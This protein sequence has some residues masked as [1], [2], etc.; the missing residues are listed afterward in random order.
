[1]SSP[2]KGS[3]LKLL[4]L[5]QDLIEQ[6]QDFREAYL[7]AN[8]NTIVAEALS[9]FINTQVDSNPEIRRRYKAARDR[10]R[11]TIDQS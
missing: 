3:R 7:D 4:G 11:K 1:M 2:S 9:V 6:M 10:R 8:E 5:D